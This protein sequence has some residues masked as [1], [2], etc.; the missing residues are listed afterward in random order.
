MVASLHFTRTFG[1]GPAVF[2]YTLVAQ[3]VQLILKNWKDLRGSVS[4]V[5]RSN[6]EAKQAFSKTF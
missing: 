2:L 4:V 5:L 6:G 1:I 3:L